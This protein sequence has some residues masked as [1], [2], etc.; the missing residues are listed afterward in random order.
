MRLPSLRGLKRTLALSLGLSSL[1]LL[2][3]TTPAEACFNEVQ[4]Q[5]TPVQNI[6]QAEKD[7]DDNRIG[8]AA[9]RVRSV[10]PEIRALGPDAPPLALRAERIYAL[11]LVRADGQLDK[12]L[13]W[14]RW[15]NLEWAIDTLAALESKRGND[16][17]AKADLAEA[18]TRLGRTRTQGIAVLEDLD[19]RDLLG[20][21]FAYLALA[22]A[23]R[24][25]GDD[26]GATAA[27]VRCAMMSTDKLRCQ[28]DISGEALPS[29]G[30]PNVPL[31]SIGA[32]RRI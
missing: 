18:R 11:L 3:D 25:T 29:T 6:A 23:R 19:R 31:P 5:L 9:S 21:P 7:L 12:Q 20:S 2:G 32:R 16:A 22:R 14:A 24:A 17:R 30:G 8:E 4:I 13:G 28:A 26:G 27:L 1:A 15:G 10:F